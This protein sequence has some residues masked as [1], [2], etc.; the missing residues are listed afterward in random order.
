[1]NMLKKAGAQAEVT[2]D[3]QRIAQAK[4]LILPGVGRFETAMHNLRQMNLYSVLIQKIKNDRVPT[5]GVCMGMQLLAAFS[6]E[7]HAEGLGLMP[8][9]VLKFNFPDNSNLRVPHMGWNFITIKKN[10]PMV[11]GLDNESR[12]YFVHS[13]YVKARDPEI[14]LTET[15]YGVNFVSGF[16]KD[17]IVGFQFHPEKSHRFGLQIYKNFVEW[18]A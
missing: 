9:E 14:S 17:N 10:H 11:R 1:M 18:Q 7:G 4:K 8:A 13:Y 5:L 15:E 12:F 16:Q 6:E 3:P 2:S